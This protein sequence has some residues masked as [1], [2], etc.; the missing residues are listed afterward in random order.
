[1]GQFRQKLPAFF[2]GRHAEDDDDIGR[3][4]KDKKVPLFSFEG[5]LIGVKPITGR[6]NIEDELNTKTKNIRKIIITTDGENVYIIDKK[7]GVIILQ[8]AGEDITHVRQNDGL[9]QCVGYVYWAKDGKQHLVKIET[10]KQAYPFTQALLKLQIEVERRHVLHLHQ[11][12]GELERELEDTEQQAS[13]Y[14][15][16]LKD[17]K[18]RMTLED[19]EVRNGCPQCEERQI[20]LS[21]RSSHSL[22]LKDS[23]FGSSDSCQS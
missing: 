12:I 6:E 8:H 11:R 7:S 22:S 15:K 5:K 9:R 1:M 13:S 4:R 16:T 2:R 23:F 18:I 19:K 3:H 10:K 21:R 14:L 20:L 17:L